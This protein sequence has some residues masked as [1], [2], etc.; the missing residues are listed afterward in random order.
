MQGKASPV[1]ILVGPPGSGKGTQSSRLVSLLSIPKISTGDILRSVASEE[2]EFSKKIRDVMSSGGFV[3]DETLALLL[4]SRLSSPDCTQ[5][6]ILDGYPRN[7]SQAR[8]LDRILDKRKYQILVLEILVSEESLIKRILGRFSCSKCGAIYN[9]YFSKP[10]VDGVCDSCGATE[11]VFRSDDNES[12]VRERLKEYE[13]Q[14][15][16]VLNFY[17]EKKILHRIDGNESSDKVYNNIV[18][19]LLSSKLIEFDK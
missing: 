10:K 14:T 9:Q 11:F 19:C 8:Y 17:D 15:L 12:V 18:S 16:P 7:V 13:R 4:T 6:F 1:I 5:G 3:S 2:S